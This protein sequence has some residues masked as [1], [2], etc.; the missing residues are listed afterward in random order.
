MV[1]DRQQHER[2]T[3]HEVQDDVIAIDELTHFRAW[4]RQLDEPL[5][6]RLALHRKGCPGRE[7]RTDLRELLEA[8]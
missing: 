3:A 2:R 7:I 1:L 5:E 6:E 8:G 4:T